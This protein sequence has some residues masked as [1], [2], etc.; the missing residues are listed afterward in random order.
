MKKHIISSEKLVF[1]QIR[2][3]IGQ[4][5]KLELS[6]ESEALIVKCR[7]YLDNKISSQIEPIY[8]V[9]TGFGALCNHNISK[10]DLC[11]LQKNLVVSHACGTGDEVPK[12]IVRLMLLLKVQSLSYGYS[13]VQLKTVQRLIDMFNNEVLP[14]IYQQG[15]LGASGDLSPLAHMSLPLLNLGEVYYKGEKKPAAE[16]C[17]VFG[18]EPID[19]QSKEG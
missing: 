1:E 6:K 3:I 13:G 10:D 18:W 2:T 12:D 19:L 15:S 9:T 14:V 4:D 5:Y 17:K 11:L 7:T 16:V 8:G